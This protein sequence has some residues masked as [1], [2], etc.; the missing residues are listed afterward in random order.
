MLRLLQKASLAPHSLLQVEL[1]NLQD[2]VTDFETLYN[3]IMDAYLPRHLRSVIEAEDIAAHHRKLRD[4]SKQECS[5]RYIK[6]VQS[7]PLYGATIFDV[8]VHSRGMIRFGC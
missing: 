6:L 3:S 5:T 7:W 4:L 8:M 2:D 1:G